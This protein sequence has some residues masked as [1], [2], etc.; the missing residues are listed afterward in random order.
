MKTEYLFV[1]HINLKYKMK[2]CRHNYHKIKVKKIVFGQAFKVVDKFE[3]Y[4]SHCVY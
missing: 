1:V 4:L 2:N 3:Y